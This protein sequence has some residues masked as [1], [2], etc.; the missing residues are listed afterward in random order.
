MHL[1]T[2][3]N[4]KDTARDLP[5][6]IQTSAGYGHQPAVAPSL[7]TTVNP[8]VPSIA[9]AW[10]ISIAWNASS[11]RMLVFTQDKPVSISMSFAARAGGHDTDVAGG[12]PILKVG[13]IEHRAVRRRRACPTGTCFASRQ[14]RLSRP[15]GT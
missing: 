10:L 11:E 13:D 15:H 2:G 8:L 12:Q 6:I 14:K 9:T 1:A 7:V 5:P 3:S 4:Y